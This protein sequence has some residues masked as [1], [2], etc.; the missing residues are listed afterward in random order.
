MFLK[1]HQWHHLV[2]TMP[3]IVHGWVLAMQPWLQWRRVSVPFERQ[4]SAVAS[5]TLSCPSLSAL[6]LSDAAGQYRPV[7]GLRL[8]S[9]PI[10]NRTCHRR[11]EPW[12]DTTHIQWLPSNRATEKVARGPGQWPGWPLIFRHVWT[13]RHTIHSPTWLIRI[14]GDK[15]GQEGSG[16]LRAVCVRVSLA[17]RPGHRLTDHQTFP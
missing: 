8:L 5:L 7:S 1:L 11:T 15:R 2:T 12:L 16:L 17:W 14:W 4:Q 9:E 13:H 3:D 10:R 6:G